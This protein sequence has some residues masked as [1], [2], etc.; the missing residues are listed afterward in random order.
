MEDCQKSSR[1]CEC[2]TYQPFTP[3]RPLQRPNNVN[4]ATVSISTTSTYLCIARGARKENRKISPQTN[5]ATE[6][7]T[8]RTT[9]STRA[10]TTLAQTALSQPRKIV[11]NRTETPLSDMLIKSCPRSARLP[12]R[13][14]KL[15]QLIVPCCASPPS[16]C[17]VATDG[18]PE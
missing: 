1:F 12:R 2:P 4:W 10:L 8:P 5:L 16:P 13:C 14:R 17:S 7:A 11:R 15:V 6:L 18:S 9:S 3:R